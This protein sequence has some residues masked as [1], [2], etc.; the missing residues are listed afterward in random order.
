MSAP[1]SVSPRLSSPFPLVNARPPVSGSH[2][3]R[4]TPPAAGGG[5]PHFPH[6]D[7]FDSSEA[8][9]AAVH[10]SAR[11]HE[12]YGVRQAVADLD[13]LSQPHHIGGENRGLGD[14]HRPA[15][16]K[17]KHAIAQAAIDAARRYFP[18]LSLKDG[19]RLILADA[20]LESTFNPRLN[21]G[22]GPVDPNKTVGLL[23]ARGASNLADFKRYAS[24]K[25]LKHADGSAWN[26]HQTP[27]NDL[28]KIWEN[29]HVGAWYISTT[30]RLG[31]TSPNEHFQQGKRGP[32]PTTVA[33]GLLS[34]FE[35]P[36]GAAEHPHNPG[37]QRYLRIVG[38]ELNYLEPGSLSRILNTRLD[39]N[40][41]V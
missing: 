26:P 15:F 34:H 10:A 1:L 19:T 28:A 9:T 30:A 35:S 16:N 6:T 8:R 14:A 41:R 13:K 7:G 23:Q 25:G 20:A 5:L 39:R 21:A 33:T 38:G 4:S 40:R 12:N 37:A 11:T 22:P 31:A 36:D 3:A 32:S 2:T 29:I 27:V 18:E 17:D 24:A